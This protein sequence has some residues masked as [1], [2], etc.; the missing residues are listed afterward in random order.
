MAWTPTDEIV[1]AAF[2]HAAA[3]QPRECCGVVSG[4]KYHPIENIMTGFDTFAMDMRAY[5]AIDK[6]GKVE[7]IVHSHVYENPAPSD[8]DLTMCEIT[9][10]PWLI[11][12]W[13]TGAYTVTEPSGFTAPLV[14][15]TWAW[16][17]HD[18]WTLV[19]DSFEHYTGIRLPYFDMPWNFWE[20]DEEL[21]PPLFAEAGLVA[22]EGAEWRH[23]DIVA[24][25]VWPS[26]VVN[27]MGLFLA[28]DTMLHQLAGRNSVRE[29]Y[30]GVYAKMTRFHLRHERF[31]AAPPPLPDH[32]YD[33]RS[34]K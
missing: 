13:P 34:G 4:G 11:V 10:K 29:V 12:N 20:R 21:I 5:L 16:A 30:G 22:V 17:C 19:R 28:P 15:R 8:A 32:Y 7:A 1:A 18:C 9:A 6:V 3:C 14:G 24:M 25:Q 2:E 26:R 23:C 33:W 27:H 31:L